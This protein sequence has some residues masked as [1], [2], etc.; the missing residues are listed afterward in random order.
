[1]H[2]NEYLEPMAPDNYN[3]DNIPIN[4]HDAY[5]KD[6]DKDYHGKYSDEESL[7][8]DEEPDFLDFKD[9]KLMKP[10]MIHKPT[11]DG[12]LARHRVGRGN[13]SDSVRHRASRLPLAF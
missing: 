5:D 1:M 11:C 6:Y 4:W 13:T 10:K 7:W 9:D 3:K 2:G 8:N 12:S